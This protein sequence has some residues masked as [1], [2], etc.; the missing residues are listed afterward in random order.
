MARAARSDRDRTL[1]HPGVKYEEAGR[2]GADRSRI[3]P[4]SPIASRVGATSSGSDA[5]SSSSKKKTNPRTKTTSSS[6]RANPRTSDLERGESL[7]ARPHRKARGDAKASTYRSALR[8]LTPGC[9]TITL[10]TTKCDRGWAPVRLARGVNRRSGVG[11]LVP[12]C[13]SLFFKERRTPPSVDGRRPRGGVGGRLGFPSKTAM[14]SACARAG[15]C[16]SATLPCPF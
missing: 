11:S 3:R 12:R 4:A 15:Q 16:P 9:N 14:G 1:D 6:S 7:S 10:K 2:S 5:Q 13:S 8:D